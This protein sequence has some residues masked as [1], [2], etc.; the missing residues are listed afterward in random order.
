M[1]LLE[2]DGRQ[3]VNV[4]AVEE[5]RRSIKVGSVWVTGGWKRDATTL[6]YEWIS[7]A[8]EGQE[9]DHAATYGTGGFALTSKHKRLPHGR[10]QGIWVEEYRSTGTWYLGTYWAE[11]WA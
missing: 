6:R 7:D 5:V 8:T 10:G 4:V 1:A 11:S 2:V 3:T 9:S